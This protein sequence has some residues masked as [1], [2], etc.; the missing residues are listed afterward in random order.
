MKRENLVLDIVF[1]K[2]REMR[3]NNEEGLV[4]TADYFQIVSRVFSIQE[5]DFETKE[6]YLHFLRF[7][8][9]IQRRVDRNIIENGFDGDFLHSSIFLRMCNY[10]EGIKEWLKK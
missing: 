6:K 8:N 4:N 9:H 2:E 7:I 5:N 1:F 10:L 3:Y